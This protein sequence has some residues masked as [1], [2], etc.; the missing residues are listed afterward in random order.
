MWK[1]GLSDMRRFLPFVILGALLSACGTPTPPTTTTAPSAAA[2]SVA[3]GSTMPDTGTPVSISL[4]YIPDVQFAPF[5]VAQERGYYAQEGLKVTIEHTFFQEAVVQVAQGQLTFALAAGDEILAARAQG[6]PIRMV[7]QV[8]QQY[9]IAIFSKASEGVATPDDLRGTTVGVPARAGATYVG[10]LGVMD[11]QDIPEDDVTIAEIGFTQAEAVQ[12]DKVPV[13]VGYINNEPLLLRENGI[14]V[15]VIPVSEYI[16]LVSNGIVASEDRISNDPD[17]IRRFLRA[18][19]RGLQDTLDDPDGAFEIAL[20]VIPEIPEAQRAQQ[21][22]KLAQ[23]LPLWRSEASEQNGLGY[24][25]PAA[26]QTTY[27]FLRD[28]GIL[29]QDIDVTEAFTNE[30]YKE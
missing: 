20:G 16:N 21:R 1:K 28:S 12:T 9:P 13:A 27:T 7:Y 30:L 6:V 29:Q 4:G 14:D 22:E 5:Y 15:N 25:D 8:Y 11:A 2:S 24:S 17:T 10:L 26:W 3:A 19:A 23:T 18:T